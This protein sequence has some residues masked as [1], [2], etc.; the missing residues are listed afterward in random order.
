VNLLKSKLRRGTAVVAGALLGL[1]GVAF[2]AAPAS[3]HDNKVAGTAA[4][5]TTAGEWV[6]TWTVNTDRK[7]SKAKN[8]RFLTVTQTPADS[9]ISG[10]A[11]TADDAQPKYPYPSNTAV[12]ATQRVAGSATT[13]SLTV[14]T[15]W[16]D[17]F[18]AFSL[19]ASVVL[20]G[21]CTKDA[22]KPDAKLASTCDG[23]TVTLANGKDAKAEADFTV[24]GSDGYTK[25]ITV[26]AGAEPVELKIPAKN[27]A[28][29]VVTEKH[30]AKPVLEGKYEK[31]T[32][33]D[34]PPKDNADRY[35]EVTC[36]SLIFTIDNTK[37]TATVTAT[38]TPNKG[39][40]QTLVVKGGETAS[41]TFKGVKGLEVTPSEGKI[42]YEPI[43]WN[44]EEKP[45]DCTKSPSPSPSA[46][47]A[48][49]GGGLPK[50]GAAAGGIAGGAAVLLAFGAVL[51]VL[52]RRRKVKF[53]A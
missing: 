41:A 20:D 8:F 26:K 21:T 31:P 4:C 48:G 42:V 25:D 28:T 6:V 29:I 36:D 47:G 50:T 19:P 23:V 27:A 5:D 35:Y 44:S 38:F 2:F 12:V 43:K 37:G 11:V 18:K 33:C 1:T 22:P 14:Q 9:T 17:T 49:G 34:Q 30:T 15:E 39:E 24:V 10:I 46:S 40:A 13:A 52:A 32:D 53:T 3:A 16:D 7:H 51:F 45:A